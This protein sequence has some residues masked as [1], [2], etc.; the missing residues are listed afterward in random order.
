MFSLF[1]NVRNV[2]PKINFMVNAKFVQKNLNHT[3]RKDLSDALINH[4]RQGLLSFLS[5]L[6]ISVLR[7]LEEE[8]DILR[9]G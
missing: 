1:W 7:N 9:L 4:G 2:K 3:S 6:P 8:A 5:S